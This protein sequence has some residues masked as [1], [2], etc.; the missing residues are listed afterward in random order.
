MPLYGLGLSL[1]GTILLN[2]CLE[3]GSTALDNISLDGLICISSPLDLATCSSCIEKPRNLI[4]QTWLLKRLV[5]QTLEDPFGL[6]SIE[7]NVLVRRNK[8]NLPF[9]SSIRLFDSAITAPRW[10]YKD[11]NDYYQ[12]ASPIN[13]LF[14]KSLD[15][16]PKTLFLHSLDDPWVPAKP[17]KA[18]QERITMEDLAYSKIDILISNKG[19]HNGFHGTNGCWGDLVVKRWLLKLTD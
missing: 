12:K 11:V 17:V 14:S 19:G 9:I 10:G 7:R 5:K 6:T 1:G 4:Y 8:W 15:R 16:I 3:I 13:K 18:L 2:A